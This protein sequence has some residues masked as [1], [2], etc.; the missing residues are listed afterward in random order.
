[1]RS[2]GSFQKNPVLADGEDHAVEKGDVGDG[3]HR[4]DQ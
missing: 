3:Q 1:M 2:K 4:S